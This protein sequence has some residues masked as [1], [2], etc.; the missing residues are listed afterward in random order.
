M[1]ATHVGTTLDHRG[2]TH[3]GTTLDHRSGTHI[4]AAPITGPA[5]IAPPRFICTVSNGAFE[6]S[7][8]RV[9]AI[10][11]A[12]TEPATQGAQLTIKVATAFLQH[13]FMKFSIE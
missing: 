6:P 13:L 8:A 2:A 5:C 10:G 3:V 11:I 12:E 7:T 1:G 4:G 9:G